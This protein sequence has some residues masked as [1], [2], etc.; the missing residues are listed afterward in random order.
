MKKTFSKLTSLFLI[1]T[2]LA[3]AFV[4]DGAAL[5][6]ESDGNEPDVFDGNQIVVTYECC[7]SCGYR[8]E[9]E[10]SADAKIIADK[11]GYCKNDGEAFACWVADSGEE[12]SVGDTLP[13]ASVTLKA[14]KI[15]LLLKGDE[16]L[17]FS[18]SDPYFYTDDF[19]GYYMNQ[20]DNRMMLRNINKVF[21]FGSPLSVGLSIALSTYPNWYWNGSCYGMSTLVFLQHHGVIDVLEDSGA[22][23]VSE[24]KNTAD[25]VSKI[26][27]YQWAASGSFLCENFSTEKGTKMFSQQLKDM[28]D[29]VSAGN[30]VLFTFYSGN[31]FNS[32][33]HTV[34]LTGAYSLDDGTHVLYA[35][36]CNSPEDYMSGACEGRFIISSDFTQITKTYNMPVTAWLNIGSF[37]WTDSCKQFEAFDIDGEGSA[38]TWY[39]QF[40]SQIISYFKTLVKIAFI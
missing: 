37:N 28:F 11:K 33:G 10:Y 16:V 8:E 21:L 40:F 9:V 6:K 35:Y 15:P 23:S 5:G 1:L 31:I 36:D 14:K 18:N 30:I 7:D 34:V 27:Y 13:N 20:D 22:A 19:N 17:S 12:Y 38:L 25:V 3:G 26:N 39:S 29:T 2:L 32:S 4:F 24:L